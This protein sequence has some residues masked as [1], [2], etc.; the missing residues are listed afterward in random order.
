MV[1]IIARIPSENLILRVFFC[2][3]Q[4][5]NACFFKCEIPMPLK[6]RFNR[7]KGGKRMIEP[8]NV[9]FKSSNLGVA[10]DVV[11]A[12]GNSSTKAGQN[13]STDGMF[14]ARTRLHAKM[15]AN[16]KGK[17]KYS[18]I[19]A[20]YV[21]N[22]LDLDMCQFLQTETH[23]RSDSFHPCLIPLHIPNLLLATLPLRCGSLLYNLHIPTFNKIIHR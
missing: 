19:Q 17:R 23:F 5:P 16:H 22:I 9:A 7:E 13:G 6:F 2:C 3:L 8:V 20:F 21:R 11:S 12:A 4:P 14:G 18:E 15:P 10:Q 1:E